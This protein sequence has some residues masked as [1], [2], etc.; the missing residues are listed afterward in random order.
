MRLLT[1]LAE[2]LDVTGER[3]APLGDTGVRVNSVHPGFIDTPILAEVKGTEF[4]DAM[5]A[6]T[7]MERLG[8]S[9]EVAAT[10][11]FLASD[12]ASFMTGLGAL[13]RR[14]LHRPVTGRATTSGRARARARATMVPVDRRHC[15]GPR[16]PLP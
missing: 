5:I 13:R 3:R 11:A 12:D 16:R 2:R 4:E 6:M 8:Q 7:P 15:D 1:K 14:R 9:D 10:I